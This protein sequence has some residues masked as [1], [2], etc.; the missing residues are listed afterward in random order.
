MISTLS[1]FLINY[2]D[3]GNDKL[4]VQYQLYRTLIHVIDYD[5]SPK[6]DV[7]TTNQKNTLYGT[8]DQDK[9]GFE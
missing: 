7:P 2:P 6:K 5:N 1:D 3:I 4:S 8:V 9:N